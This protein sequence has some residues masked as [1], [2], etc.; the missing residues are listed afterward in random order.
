MAQKYIVLGFKQSGGPATVLAD[1]SVPPPDQQ[2][3]CREHLMDTNFEEVQMFMLTPH[4]RVF[5]P[6][7]E[8]AAQKA[9]AQARKTSPPEIPKAVE[10]KKKGIFQKTG[11]RLADK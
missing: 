6:K 8:A 11:E 2:Q 3:I 7:L 9:D 4:M 1:P 10:H 5:R